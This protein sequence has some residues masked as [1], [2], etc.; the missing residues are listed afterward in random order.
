MKRKKIRLLATDTTFKR[1]TQVC[2]SNFLIL[3]LNQCL[4][5]D[6]IGWKRQQGS[7]CHIACIES[8]PACKYLQPKQHLSLVLELFF[9]FLEMEQN[10]YSRC[11]LRQKTFSQVRGHFI[12]FLHNIAEVQPFVCTFT[13]KCISHHKTQATITQKHAFQLCVTTTIFLFLKEN[14]DFNLSLMAVG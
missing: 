10:D 2:V 12:Y 13:M 3:C 11:T 1:K 4:C 9:S 7:Q 5:E 6:T 14:F 8:L